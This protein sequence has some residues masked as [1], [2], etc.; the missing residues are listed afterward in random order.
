MT[1][2]EFWDSSPMELYDFMESYNRRE[3][4][5]LKQTAM[6]QY[7]QAVMIAQQWAN[8]KD[9]DFKPAEIWDFY[10]ELFADEKKKYEEEQAAEEWEAFKERRREY[11][12]AWNRRRR[13]L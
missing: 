7:N 12:A 11:A 3:T 9:K 2:S 1:I 4:R 8:L 10:P 6:M 5:R 13:G